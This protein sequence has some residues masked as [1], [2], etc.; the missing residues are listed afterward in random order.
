MTTPRIQVTQLSKRFR[1]SCSFG[2]NRGTLVQGK[3]FKNFESARWV[4]KDISFQIQPGESAG[5]IGPNSAG[6]TTLLRIISGVI[7]PSQGSV[8]TRGKVAS[9]LGI[10]FHPDLT[11][12][13]CIR[14]HGS[15][16]GLGRAECEEMAD[17]VLSLSGVQVANNCPVKFL[18][19][20]ALARIALS[21][22]LH[23][24]AQVFL[25][26]EILPVLDSDFLLRLK[27]TLNHLREQG[28]SFLIASHQENI[29]ASLCTRRIYLDQGR[30]T[31][32]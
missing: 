13:E 26:D 3:P 10:A 16:Y 8:L 28:K 1:F 17:R 18:N 9:I 14:F 23:S 21:I 5:I 2:T 31:C 29:I 4:L 25:F 20:G 22:A 6:K 32:L 24:Q 7:K 12:R 15:F 11:S 19:K 27:D 30:A